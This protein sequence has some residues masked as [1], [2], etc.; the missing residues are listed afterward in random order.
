MMELTGPRQLVVL[1]SCL[2]AV[3]VSRGMEHYGSLWVKATVL[4]L[5]HMTELTGTQMTPLFL[6]LVKESHGM[7]HYGSLWVKE[8]INSAIH[9]MELTGP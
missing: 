2:L 8:H 1:V 6:L 7:E 4:S 9:M 5:I 3:M